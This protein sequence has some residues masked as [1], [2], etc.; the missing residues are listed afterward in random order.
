[1][2]RRNFIAGSAAMAAASAIPVG[3]SRA[4]VAGS[5][6]NLAPRHRYLFLDDIHIDRAVG[7]KTLGHPAKRYEGN[8]LFVKKYPWENV[9]IQLYGHCI[10]YN[11]ERKLYQMYYIAYPQPNYYPN[12]RV[13][14]AVKI[15]AATLPAYAESSDGIH[16]DRPLRKD[17]SFN[18]VKETNL[19]DLHKGTSFEAGVL[20]DVHDPDPNRRYK[21]FVWDQNFH[22]PVPGK[23]NYRLDPPSSKYPNGVITTFLQ[24][25][26]GKIVH[27]E[28]YN[29]WG[30]RVAFSPDGIH[31]KKHPGWVFPCYSDT[32]QSVLYDPPCGKYFAFGRFN[33]VRSLAKLYHTGA[34]LPSETEDKN[35]IGRNGVSPSTLEYIGRNVARMESDDFIHWSEPELV[36]TGDSRDPESFQINSMPVD[37]YEGL[38]IGIMEVDNRPFPNSQLPIQLAVSRDSRRWSRVADRIPFIETS[39]PG[40]WDS[41]KGDDPHGFIRPAGGLF[42]HGDEVRMYYSNLSGPDPFIGVGM[43]SWRR[44]GFVSLHVG[45]EEG[46]LLTR[47]FIPT[48]PELH[49]NLDASQGEA[50]V[51]VGDF[52]GRPLA[53]WKIDWPSEPIHGD[54][55]DTVVRWTGS[56]FPY[57]IGQATTLRIRMRNADLY[58]F[59]TV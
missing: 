6:E 49:L 5:K 44:D 18:T 48:G 27:E 17:V 19:L 13:G 9:R 21:A 16:W 59:W 14:G 24:D 55:I 25:E 43:A 41:D 26:S 4:E 38:F 23:V 15:G 1:M 29:D 32:G 51:R 42:V 31:W 12:I 53:G 3:S 39:A 11:A 50:T 20:W 47:S 54:R 58:S 37:S 52:Q 8:P 10:V 28:P 57:R 35:L 33:Q 45:D 22:G 56:D 46:E 34:D 40:T 30:I 2:N 36:L 7:L